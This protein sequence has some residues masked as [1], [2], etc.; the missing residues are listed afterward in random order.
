MYE[1]IE[2]TEESFIKYSGWYNATITRVPVYCKL[3]DGKEAFL[4]NRLTG[5][6]ETDRQKDFYI[7]NDIKGDKEEVKDFVRQLK[8]NNGKW[9]D[10]YGKWTWHPE[11][12]N[13]LGPLKFIDWVKSKGY[14]FDEKMTDLTIESCGTKFMGNLNEYSC[15]F[16]YDILDESIVEEIKK[17]IPDII[18]NN[19]Q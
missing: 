4:L 10:R 19:C 12:T 1:I 17:R 5:A 11:A 9:F 3:P 6:I 15:A 8:K 7:V 18:I 16:C 2:K 13:G 14:T